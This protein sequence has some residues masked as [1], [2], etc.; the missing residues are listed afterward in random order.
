MALHE[1]QLKGYSV[2]P[3][4]LSLGTFD[5]YGIEQLH[6]T[7]DDTWSGLAVTATFN[8]PE[9]EP[10]EIRVPENG[11]IDV[12]A[13]ATANEGTGTIV[14]C[15]VAN[16]VQ[17]ISKTQGY[18]VIT[19]GNVGTTVPFNPSESL[20]TQVLQ[21]ALSAEQSSAEAKS[22]ADGLRTDAASG[23]FNGKDGAKGDKGD[24]GPQGPVGPQGPQGEQGIQ[25]PT[26][27]TGA[28]GPQGPRGEK[29]NTGAKGADGVSPTAAVTQTDDGAKFT[30]TDARGTTTATIKNGTN[31]KD[32]A[33]GKP[34]KDAVV[35]A[36]LTQDGQAADAKVTG[37]KIG[38][39]KEDLGDFIYTSN[40]DSESKYST[41]PVSVVPQKGDL[42]F[43]AANECSSRFFDRAV[44][45]LQYAENDIDYIDILNIGDYNVCVSEK[46]YTK[47][48]VSFV[49]SQLDESNPTWKATVMSSGEYNLS[50]ILMQMYALLDNDIKLRDTAIENLKNDLISKHSGRFNVSKSSANTFFDFDVKTGD[51][52]FIYVSETNASN[53]T[54]YDLYWHEP[55]SDTFKLIEANISDVGEIRTYDNSSGY[56]Y[57]RIIFKCSAPSTEDEYLTCVFTK[58]TD[59]DAF[60]LITKLFADVKN[61]KEIS[62][63]TA[64][65]NIPDVA[66]EDVLSTI[67]IKASNSKKNNIIG[68]EANFENMG[69][70]RIAHGTSYDSNRS[71]SIVVDA[72]NVYLYDK[73]TNLRATYPHSLSMDK[74]IT[75]SIVVGH[76]R[77]AKVILTTATGRFVQEDVYWGGCCED[78]TAQV[79]TGTFTNARLTW[80]VPDYNYDLWC[81]GDSYFDFWGFDVIQRLGFH[82][83]MFD[84][85]GGRDSTNAF[86]SL[87][88][89]LE[90]AVPKKI[91][92]CL[93]MNDRDTET[94]I[95]AKWKETVDS[96][97]DL[98]N[99]K[100][101]ELILCT[102]PETPVAVHTF[103][104][105]YVKASG[106]R[107]VDV[108]HA[109]GADV[110]NTWYDGLLN[111][112]DRI[113][114]TDLGESVIADY[115]IANVPELC[116]N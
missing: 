70:V 11:L 17:R 9:G 64:K 84:G 90:K 32:G 102:I 104:N 73:S 55:T 79:V 77:T 48:T 21:A 2:R 33:P 92:W 24:T 45:M 81:F 43:F 26:G 50:S 110:S 51:K 3:G 108:C 34:G 40:W 30:V 12:P 94:A 86:V 87:K 107:Y 82:N 60:G 10:V 105:A 66:Y 109:V 28:T 22:V 75:V 99:K 41:Q 25:G 39:L 36:T 112:T 5:S 57:L 19:H 83:F 115:M 74:F 69:S 8:P 116:V 100:G 29:G 38:K 85:F 31:G 7:L 1:V 88:L 18:S 58:D 16:G 67:T 80:Y 52:G 15:G 96:I 47:A 27:A 111:E 37:E 114:P 97:M 13:E 59:A 23:K 63:T 91:L 46:N 101:I 113:H 106:K 93:G 68:F 20:A 95:N 103:K 42:I 35:D 78:I 14:Y 65:V 62:A 72:T 6:V 61:M 54:A 71:A 76:S 4:N 49:R 53:F 98:C 44:L 56:D 89:A